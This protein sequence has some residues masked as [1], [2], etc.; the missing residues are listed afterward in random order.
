M[1]Q[2]IENHHSNMHLMAGAVAMPLDSFAAFT[3]F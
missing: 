3:R 1:F 2:M